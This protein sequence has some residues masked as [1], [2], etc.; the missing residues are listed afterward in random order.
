MAKAESN[1]K[2]TIALGADHAG[3]ELKEALKP[4]L[5]Q[6]GYTVEDC[7]TFDA[8]PADYP[9]IAYEVA[10]RVSDGTCARGVIIDGAGI[11]SA[12]VANKVPGIRAALCHDVSSAR[13]SREHNDANVLTLGAGFIGAGLAR[14]IVDVW[15]E[16]ECTVQRHLDR[17][18]MIA[19]LESGAGSATASGPPDGTSL[20]GLSP[21]DVQRIVDRVAGLTQA[22]GGAPQV[23]CTETACGFC[24]AAPA[25]DADT[26]RKFIELGAGRICHRPGAGPLPRELAQYIDHTLL[27]PEASEDQ[28][29]Q[30]CEEAVEYGFATVCVN[31]SNVRLAARLVKGSQV[32]VCS[33]AGFPLGAHETEIKSAEARRAIRA[34]AREIDMVINIGALVGGDDQRVYRDIAAVVDACR[35]GRSTCKVIIEAAL[36]ND[37]QKTRACR[38]AKRA[39]AHYVKTSTGF[40]PGGA[41]A[42]DVA[43][44]AD[45]VRGTSM[46]V[47]AAGGI[48]SFAD[49][50][51]MIQ[52]GATRIGASCGVA[53][54]QE[55]T[56]VTESV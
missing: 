21:E 46:G 18:A 38:L 6:H 20:D 7:G 32:K 10:R 55:A 41:T 35:E 49:A 4:Y 17:V 13:N 51:K 5:E 23:C 48:R 39:R 33:V 8:A 26:V 11:G 30:L 3:Y 22:D 36:L 15:L 28:I 2:R 54:V 42:H 53:I 34:G 1:T 37:E 52:A 40:G 31:P 45:A 19:E 44:M 16:T 29:R 27:R 25:A 47:K 43:L 24:Q 14:Q 50:Q 9:K 56:G 12:M